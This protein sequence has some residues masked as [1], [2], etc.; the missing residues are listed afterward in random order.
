MPTTNEPPTTLALTNALM[1]RLVTLF[2]TIE[3]ASN[4]REN[5]TDKAEASEGLQRVRGT[6]PF[7]ILILVW[8]STR[9][10]AGVKAYN[11]NQF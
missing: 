11:W 4:R 3:V 6:W 5:E 1:V 9:T 7:A 8:R 10:P 2:A